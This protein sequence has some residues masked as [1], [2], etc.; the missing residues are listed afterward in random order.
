MC[1]GEETVRTI[2]ESPLTF[3]SGLEWAGVEWR[4]AV[5]SRRVPEPRTQLQRISALLNRAIRIT[6]ASK[7]SLVYHTQAQ[8]LSLCVCVCV[9]VCIRLFVTVCVRTYLCLC[10][11]FAC[12]HFHCKQR[13]VWRYLRDDNHS[14]CLFL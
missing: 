5:V 4:E 1:Y 3:N 8:L 6:A 14:A 12:T 11:V 2:M 13:D 9:C 10:V 7:Q